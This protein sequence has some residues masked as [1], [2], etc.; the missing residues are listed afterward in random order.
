MEV[1]NHNCPFHPAPAWSNSDAHPPSREVLG[2]VRVAAYLL[3]YS[4]THRPQANVCYE[5]HNMDDAADTESIQT[6]YSSCLLGHMMELQK[7]RQVT[8]C[9]QLSKS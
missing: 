2:G 1:W 3:K 9:Y 5:G 6:R 7:H 4:I 8:N